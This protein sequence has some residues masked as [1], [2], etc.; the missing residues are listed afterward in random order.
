MRT[1]SD[2]WARMCTRALARTHQQQHLS[3]CL[4]LCV[5]AQPS[6]FRILILKI[7][8]RG[9]CKKWQEAAYSNGVFEEGTSLELSSINSN[10]L[11]VSLL[12]VLII[13]DILSMLWE[14]SWYPWWPLKVVWNIFTGNGDRGRIATS[15]RSWQMHTLSTCL[16]DIQ[17]HH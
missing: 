14:T 9:H 2:T 10:E 5:W 1:H 17:V 7:H 13:A 11:L 4:S 6:S 15:S 16:P 8:A 3:A 12:S